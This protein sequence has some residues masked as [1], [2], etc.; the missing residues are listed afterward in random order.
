[1]NKFLT[2]SLLFSLLFVGLSSAG[3]KRNKQHKKGLK[4]RG[5]NKVKNISWFGPVSEESECQEYDTDDIDIFNSKKKDPS[6]FC[7]DVS[8]RTKK[9]FFYQIIQNLFF[10]I[11]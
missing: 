10:F 8:P 11:G 4:G 1:M 9:P 5:F 6:E 2:Y 3:P 7:T